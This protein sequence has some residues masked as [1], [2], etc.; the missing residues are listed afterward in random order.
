MIS[1]I[2]LRRFS[3]AVPS[4]SKMYIDYSFSDEILR[5]NNNEIVNKS[6]KFM[7]TIFEDGKLLSEKKQMIYSTRRMLERSFQNNGMILVP[8]GSASNQL[9]SSNSDLDVVLLPSKDTEKCKKFLE[10][11]NKNEFFRTSYMN[12]VRDIIKR[13]KISK[14][15]ISSIRNAKVPLVM[16]QAK[17]GIHVDIQFGNIEPIRSSLF[18]RTCVEFD[19]RV[20]PI[21]LWMT[22]K[23]LDVGILDSK[24]G[25]F[26]KYHVN[27]LVLH[28]LQTMPY[29]ILPDIIK[30]SPW[31][32]KSCKYWNAV[33]VLGKQGSLYIPSNEIPNELNFGE[34]IVQMIDYFSQI[35][36]NKCAIDTRGNL[37]ERSDL[38][39]SFQLIDSYFSIP[40]TCR[41]K[42][43]LRPP[44]CV[45]GMM[46][47]EKSKFETS[48]DF[49][50]LRIATEDI[51]LITRRVR[52]EK[53]L[54]GHKFKELKNIMN[55][56]IESEKFLVFHPEKVENQETK[57]EILALLQNELGEE[58]VNNLEW[59]EMRKVLTF[60]NWDQKSL[61]KSIL[62]E[63]LDYSSYTQTGHIVHCN[64]ADNILPYRFI[65]ADILL[66][67]VKQC[68]T[69]VQKGSSITNIYRNLD[70]VLLAGEE[71]YI[72]ELKEDGLRFKLDFSKVYWNSR[73][74][75][76]HSR[77]SSKFDQF[78][79]VYDICCGIGPFVLP[80]WR[81]KKPRRILANDLNPDSVKWLRKNI[82]IN[83][84]KSDAIE[85]YNIDGHEMIKTIIPDDAIRLMKQEDFE[86]SEKSEIHIVMNLPAYATNFLPSFRGILRNKNIEEI[87][88]QRRYKWNVYCYLF[89]KSS[90]DV[91]DD[92]F[93]KE[94]R[95]MCD[96]IIDWEE[97]MVKSCHN[98]RTVSSRKEMFC[99]HLEIPYSYLT[100]ELKNENEQ[101]PIP[102]KSKIEE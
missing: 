51:S 77:L 60:D 34:V 95:R 74:S 30:L 28:F 92:W 44:E 19:E 101:E 83:K 93:E 67:K 66:N 14:S 49:P 3:H 1:T 99:V 42:R 17:N 13:N 37:L 56:S 5:K 45:R 61:I 75:Q 47:L 62:P 78:S 63:N 15:A 86:N 82:E 53:Y 23:F 102:K 91:P 11:F 22:Q 12:D 64:F 59:S 27:S 50:T 65:L 80:A 57:S 16:F 25:F 39:S 8:I 33:Q 72:T 4:T 32:D 9:L 48:I 98:I 76:E 73:L 94:A 89:A 84:I 18:V 85:V 79:I 88:E 96:D 10:R 69:V 35:D 21:I 97:S 20:R 90:I 100:A 43:V 46:K 24:N 81:K 6:M 36:F 54:I 87:S 58:K 52:L 2:I 31:L 70:L 7:S 40:T 26:S 38:T 68:R 71:D 29:P 55:S 41:M